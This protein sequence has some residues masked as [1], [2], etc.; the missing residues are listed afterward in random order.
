M[1]RV[2]DIMCI[3]DVKVDPQPPRQAGK[4]TALVFVQDHPGQL[5]VGVPDPKSGG[6]KGGFTP[7]I[8]IRTAKAHFQMIEIKWK[9]RKAN[10]TNK[11]IYYC[12][13][14]IICYLNNQL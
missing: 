5:K 7:S 4:F 1:P 12:Y 2:G 14:M 6:Y 11:Q 10:N 8:H 9:M 3:D 13:K